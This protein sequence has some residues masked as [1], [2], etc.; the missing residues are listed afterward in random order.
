MKVNFELNS[1]FYILF[2][3]L[4]GKTLICSFDARDGN[5]KGCSL[6]PTT[7]TLNGGVVYEKYRFSYKDFDEFV[8]RVG[9]YEAFSVSNP[10][11]MKREILECIFKKL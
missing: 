2:F 4:D 9:S 5:P 10:Q 7:V 8:E 6:K 3:D 11:G 1:A